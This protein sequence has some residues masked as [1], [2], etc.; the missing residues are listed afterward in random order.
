[1]DISYAGSVTIDFICS[2][3]HGEL[4]ASEQLIHSTWRISI[5]PCSNCDY[6]EKEE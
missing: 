5:D 4:T 2:K 3:C 6:D 1:M